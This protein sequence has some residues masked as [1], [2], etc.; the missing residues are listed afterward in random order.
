MTKSA[1][2]ASSTTDPAPFAWAA[3]V[4][5]RQDA[6]ARRTAALARQHLVSVLSRQGHAVPT[7]VVSPIWVP[8]VNTQADGTPR[9]RVTAEDVL[10]LAMAAEQEY[11]AH[12]VDVELRLFLDE[13]LAAGDAFVDAAPRLGFAALTAATHGAPVSVIA[14]CPDD[15]SARALQQSATQSGATI[16]C[17][18]N[19]TVDHAM[20][21]D[22]DPTAYVVLHAGSA[23]ALPAVLAG[24]RNA[25]QAGLIGVIAW[26][27]SPEPEDAPA[28]HT[29]Q[30][31]L[32]ILGFSPFVLADGAEGMELVPAAGVTRHQYTFSLSEA[33]IARA[34]RASGAPMPATAVTTSDGY[35]DGAVLKTHARAL[36]E[37]ISEDLSP[38]ATALGRTPTRGELAMAH[39]QLHWPHARVVSFDVFDTLL[40]RKVAA[41]T[42]VFL[43]L[44]SHAPFSVAVLDARHLAEMREAA[45]REARRRSAD[46][47]GTGEVTLTE[48]HAVLA[49]QLGWRAEEVPA[50]VAAE[51]AIELAVC[52]AHPTLRSWFHEARQGGKAVWC[53]SD[54]YHDAAFLTRLL[55]HC[56]YDMRDVLVVASCEARCSKFQG[57]LFEQVIKVQRRAPAEVL[58]VG[59]HSESDDAVPA[60]LG[61][62]T[63][64]HPWAASRGA[65]EASR[66]GGDALA[67]GLAARGARCHE[68]PS[69][70]WWRFGYSVAGPLLSGFALWLAERF[71]ADR[72]D[73]AYFL[74]RDGEI[75]LEVFRA[76]AGELP[77]VSMGLLESSR[78]A[79]ALPAYEA[80]RGS[81]LAQLTVSENPRPVREFFQRWGLSVHAFAA[82]IAAHGFASADDVVR[83]DDRA[84]R[85]A[86]AQ[87]LRT[88]KV[89]AALRERSR[90][91]REVLLAYLDQ[92]GVLAGGTV[93]FVDV[94]WNATIQRSLVAALETAG[95]AQTIHGYYLGTLTQAHTGTGAGTARGYLFESSMPVSRTRA[96]MRLPQLLEFVCSTTRGSLKHF[97]RDGGRVVPVH[98]AVDHDEA[99]QATHHALRAG[100]MAYAR[101]LAAARATFGSTTISPEAALKR[102]A[103]VVEHPTYEEASFIGAI[104][105][106]DGLGADRTRALAQFAADAWSVRDIHRARTGAYWPAGLAAQRHPQALILRTLQWLAEDRDG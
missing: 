54:T 83:P 29:A 1:P 90:T 106:G 33:F 38:G 37:A 41:P 8:S 78:R 55:T 67:L 48:I 34:A 96:V 66:D 39:W 75:L 58:H 84:A 92:E 80:Q 99:Q 42:D 94:G 63:I 24:A 5:A 97:V 61:L 81:L 53:L 102:F 85:A 26:Q 88:P 16:S 76:V 27:Y 73:R 18:T 45:E 3:D 10:A 4:R 69:P 59:D 98:G 50:M 43:L 62:R 65:D 13:A 21:P 17:A 25:L 9:F 2:F 72:I 20:L 14:L 11:G 51:Q 47:R 60:G 77:G 46:T 105:H 68:P 52:E 70:F 32:D 40:T 35:T 36:F 103:R 95:R 82:E 28:T 64:L 7:D 15:A 19:S 104:Q 87:L 6:A 91:E 22:L 44:A 79:F 57:A 30:A 71:R 74:L 101:D 86:L 89:A 49:E 31:I 12:G 100:V 56:G 93:A 23:A